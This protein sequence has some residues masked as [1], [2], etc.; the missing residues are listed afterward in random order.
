LEANLEE[1]EAVTEHREVPNEEAAVETVGALKDRRLGAR[2]RGRF[3]RRA[4]PGRRKCRSHKGLTVEKRRRA[5]LKCNNDI[6][7]RGLKQQLRLGSKGNVNETLRGTAVLAVVKLAAGSS[8]GIQ[9]M[10]VK[11]MWRSRPP[12]KR[13]EL[14][15]QKCWSAGHARLVLPVPT[16]KEEMAVSV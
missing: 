4:V 1:I 15:C 8:V 9:K 14:K 2:R 12:H 7:Y 16:G 6:R 5:Q 13:K 3:T 10:S 11:T